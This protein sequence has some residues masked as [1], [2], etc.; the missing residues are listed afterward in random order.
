MQHYDEKRE[1]IIKRSRG[2][3]GSA[4]LLT[5]WHYTPYLKPSWL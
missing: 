3:P 1:I 2:A 4:W 5:S